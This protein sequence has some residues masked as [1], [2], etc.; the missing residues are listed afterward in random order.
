QENFGESKPRFDLILLGMGTDGHTASLFPHT[1][2]VREDFRLFVANDV[3]QLETKR[4]TF[5]FPLINAARRALFLVSGKDKADVLHA[6]LEGERDLDR[7]PSQG[8]ALEDGIV[9]WMIA[10]QS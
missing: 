8:V 1:Q 5:T 9:T 3:P 7:L 2:A 6:V 10:D 4:L